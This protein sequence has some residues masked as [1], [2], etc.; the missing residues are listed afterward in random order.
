MSGVISYI[1]SA[2]YI[3]QF[4]TEE[5]RQRSAI[6]RINMMTKVDLLALKLEKGHLF[7][8]KKITEVVG[9]LL[10]VFVHYFF[11]FKWANPVGRIDTTFF[12]LAGTYIL[13][14]DY[15]RLLC[16]IL[17]ALHLIDQSC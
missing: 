11:V 14:V 2:L 1:F 9:L 3:T 4:A 8:R 16:L 17:S 7:R 13:G 10:S 6:A 5:L 15:A 12:V